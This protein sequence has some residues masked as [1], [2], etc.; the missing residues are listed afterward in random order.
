MGLSDFDIFGMPGFTMKN[1]K[2]GL[3]KCIC[4]T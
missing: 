2:L 3:Y 4:F 1:Y